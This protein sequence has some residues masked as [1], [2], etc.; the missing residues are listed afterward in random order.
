VQ[1]KQ[2][3]DFLYK[4]GKIIKP[5]FYLKLCYNRCHSYIGVP[6][7]LIKDFA[8]ASVFFKL[9][10]PEWEIINLVMFFIILVIGATIFGHFEIKFEFADL[11]RHVNNQIN[12]ELMDIHDS[13]VKKNKRR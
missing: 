1:M 8:L 12:P 6:L 2:E 10:F 11:E 5:F 7:D 3:K 13:V 9:Y 4:L